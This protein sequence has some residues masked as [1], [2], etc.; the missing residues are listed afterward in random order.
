M[1]MQILQ[2][3]HQLSKETFLQTTW[4]ICNG[5]FCQQTT[6]VLFS[7]EKNNICKGASYVSTAPQN[8]KDW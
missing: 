1:Q 5:T 2:K 4:Y 7:E 6:D 3:N 8:Y